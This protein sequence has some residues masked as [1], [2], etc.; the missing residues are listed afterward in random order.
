MPAMSQNNIKKNW[1]SVFSKAPATLEK[2]SK[3]NKVASAFNSCI[4]SVVKLSGE[5]LFKLIKKELLYMLHMSS[6]LLFIQEIK[7]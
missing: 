6:Y 7:L 4:D 1:N 5:E 2:M 3:I